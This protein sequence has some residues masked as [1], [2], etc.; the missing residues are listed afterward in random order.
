MT[1]FWTVCY[2][3]AVIVFIVWILGSSQSRQRKDT[4][5]GAGAQGTGRPSG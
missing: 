3:V 1:V 4:G 5:N 2:V